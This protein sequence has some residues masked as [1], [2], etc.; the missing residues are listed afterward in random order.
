MIRFIEYK[1]IDKQKW[2]RCIQQSAN[3]SIYVYSWYLDAVCAN[4]SAL[5]L[6]DYETVFPLAPRSK[7]TIS[8]LYQPFFTR[9]FGAFS[10]RALTEQSVNSLFEAI[11]HKYK[12]IEFAVNE[13][14]IFNF[15]E[16]SKKER[17][18]QLLNLNA[19]YEA[20][21][22][23]Y[24]DNTKRNIKKAVNTG[25]VVRS[26]IE[27]QKIVDLFKLTKGKELKELKERDYKSLVQLMETAEKMKRAESIAVY[28]KDN[29]LCAAGFFM[30]NNSRLTF[31]KSGVTDQGKNSGAM[32]FLFDTIIKKNAETNTV[33]DFGGSSVETVA[34]F[35]KSFGAKDCVYLQLKKNSLPSIVKW[36]SKKQ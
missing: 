14:T 32:Q 27:A 2:D 34:R 33:L 30:K 31:L 23:A 11:P 1:N 17:V 3:S 25:L 24:S 5:V 18:Y 26:G 16:F 10:K 6:N 35:Y 12:F 28:D 9:Y 21:Y 29:T 22:K 4:W 15:P 7:Y 19:D 36:I 13:T 8:Y 20:L